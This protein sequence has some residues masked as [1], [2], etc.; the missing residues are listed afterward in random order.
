L[1]LDVS[2]HDIFNACHCPPSAPLGHFEL[3]A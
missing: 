2:H 3:I 1:L